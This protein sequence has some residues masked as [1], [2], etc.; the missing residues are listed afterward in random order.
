MHMEAERLRIGGIQRFSTEDGPGI[1]TTVFLGGCPLRCRWCHNPEL[2]HESPGVSWSKKKCVGCGACAGVCPSGALYMTSEGM[3]IRH[4]S[5]TGCGKCEKVCAA[6]ALRM[7]FHLMTVEEILEEAEKDKDFYDNTGGGIT[8]SGGEVLMQGRQAIRLADAA[9]ADGISV[10]VETS[11]MGETEILSELGQRCTNILFDLKHMDSHIHRQ[12]TGVPTEV[13]HRNLAY[14]AKEAGDKITVRIPLIRD[15]ND[16]LQNIADT[17]E[18]MK[19]LGL[20][21]VE[22]LPY[23]TMGISK[24]RDCGFTQERFSAP[25]EKD[26]ERILV[27]FRQRGIRA[28]VMGK[29]EE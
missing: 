23:H 19:E 2:M 3:K 6:G 8:L 10:A 18:F 15:L 9:E 28:L 26:M 20:C 14:L 12:Y 24:A 16:T 17:A 5:C 4:G 29:S 11:G 27:Q 7:C 25:S 21:R 13:I 1:R 22:L